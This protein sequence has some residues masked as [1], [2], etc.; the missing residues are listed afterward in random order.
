MSVLIEDSP[1]TFLAGWI[2]D[3]VAKGIASGAVITPWATAWLPPSGRGKKPR[4]LDRVTELQA[5]GVETW[6][7]PTTH[8]LQMGDVGDYRFYDEYDLWTGPRGDLSN[9]AY[10][11]GHVDRVFDVQD[12]LNVRHVAP[13]VLLHAA[14]DNTSVQALDLA[15][16]AIRRDPN[17]YLSIAG[18]SPFWS[19]GRALDAH[20]GA[21]ATLQPGGWFLTVVRTAISLPVAASVEEI[22]GLCRSTRALSEDAPVHISHG[23]LAGLPAVAAGATSVGSGWDQRQRACC[24]GDY[25]ERDPDPAGGGSWF[26]R[27][28]LQGL[29]GLI[30]PNEALVL[31]SRDA[32][33]VTRL[34]GLPA[35][36]AREVFDHHLTVLTSIIGSL[37]TISN[38]QQKYRELIRLYQTARAEW[39]F[40]QAHTNSAY[41]AAQWIDPFVAGLTRYGATEGW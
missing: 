33:L 29:L 37:Q 6:F 8:A 30:M 38:P 15:K 22:H 1:R 41:G 18:T 7:D 14:L 27:P 19:G 21:L 5:S 39:P 2:S 24:Y 9:Q 26:K 11:E 34:G 31:A 12:T 25:S 20:I 13:T 35:P 3:S 28:T 17:C 40:V 32:N 16:E 36:G 23:D 10:V 4:A